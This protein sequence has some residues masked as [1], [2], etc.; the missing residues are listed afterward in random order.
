MKATKWRVGNLMNEV[1]GNAT[2]CANNAQAFASLLAEGI[3]VSD[4]AA[5]RFLKTIKLASGRINREV[6]AML[7]DGRM[8]GFDLEREVE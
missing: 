3:P 7:K 4:R 5:V 1:S 6:T 8:E 2:V